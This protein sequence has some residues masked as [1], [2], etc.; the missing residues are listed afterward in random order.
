VHGPNVDELDPFLAPLEAERGAAVKAWLD[1]SLGDC[2]AC[3]QPVRVIDPH[4]L[5]KAGITHRA[6]ATGAQ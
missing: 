3:S 6:C 2:P 4:E 5:G 1:S